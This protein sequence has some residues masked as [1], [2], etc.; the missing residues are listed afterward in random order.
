MTKVEF[1]RDWLDYAQALGA[2]GALVLAI[3][4][5]VFARSSA[6]DANRSAEAAE[7]TAQ[8]AEQTA[9]VQR[10][11]HEAFMEDRRQRPEVEM[12]LDVGEMKVE[13]DGRTTLLVTAGAINRGTRT[14]EKT[15]ILLMVP[16]SVDIAEC[17]ATSSNPL[18]RTGVPQTARTVAVD[19]VKAPAHSRNGTRDLRPKNREVERSLLTFHSPGRYEIKVDALHPEVEDGSCI[20]VETITIPTAAREPGNGVPS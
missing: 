20:R 17:D 15:L 6:K 16:R 4:A 9:E 13:K 7:R 19:G 3:V 1:A 12:S 14:A 2:I 10:E 5:A 8:A 11:Q 18:P